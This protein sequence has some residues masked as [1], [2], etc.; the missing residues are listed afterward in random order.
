[1][2]DNFETTINTIVLDTEAKLLAVTRQSIQDLVDD[3]QTPVAKGG[4]MRVKTGFLRASG[5]SSLNAPPAGPSRGESDKQYVYSG[6]PINITLGQME[7]GDIFYW[8]WTAAYARHR[9]AFD[10]FL[11]SGLQ[12][13]QTYVDANVRKLKS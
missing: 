6:D 7:I 4:K 2:P 10:G 1:M 3:I 9:E 5:L 12:K 13:W 8:G 11:E